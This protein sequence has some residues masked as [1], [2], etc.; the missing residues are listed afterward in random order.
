MSTLG[1]HKCESCGHLIGR[2]RLTCSHCG[3][4]ASIKTE[5]TAGIDFYKTI[6]G[7]FETHHKALTNLFYYSVNVNTFLSGNDVTAE[8]QFENFL[9][10]W[11]EISTRKSTRYSF[12]RERREGVR[13]F[14]SLI[15]VSKD[16]K[17]F[18]FIA[19]DKGI[20]YLCEINSKARNYLDKKARE[21]RKAEQKRKFDREIRDLNAALD[22][23]RI[24]LEAKQARKLELEEIIEK[25]KSKPWMERRK[26]KCTSTKFILSEI[27]KLEENIMELNTKIAVRKE[28]WR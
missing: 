17:F 11:H 25:W 27:A 6:S 5:L 22:R 2:G 8:V 9:D 14:Q 10:F 3:A 1:V 23:Y 28:Q 16:V 4:A 13:L 18:R 15:E 20:L 21:V 24:S 12:H 7:D 19:V 26:T